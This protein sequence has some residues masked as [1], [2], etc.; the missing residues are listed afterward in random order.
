MNESTETARCLVAELLHQGVTEA[1][2]A[3]GSRSAPLAFALLAAADAGRVRLHVRLD[4]RDAGFLALGLAKLS[5]APVVV[6]C[7]SGTA[8]ANLSPAVVEASFSAVPLVVVTADRPLESRGVGS[9]QTIDQ[10]DFFGRD[11][12]FSADL[13]SERGAAFEPTGLTDEFEHRIRGTVAHAIGAAVGRDN[14]RV[15]PVHVNVGFR[16]PLVP[17]PAQ[18][19]QPAEA[20]PATGPGRAGPAV[21]VGPARQRRQPLLGCGTADIGEVLADEF[22][23]VPT[24]GVIV[25][26]DLPQTTLRGAQQWLAELAGACGWPIVAEPSANL[27]GAPTALRHGVLVLGAPGFLERHRP[28]LVLSA[29]LWGLSRPTLGLLRAAHHHLVLDLPGVGRQVCD[30]TRTAQRVLEA[31]PLPP[32]HPVADPSWLAAWRSAEAAVAAALAAEPEAGFTGITAACLTAAAVPAGGLLVTAPSWPVRHLE[33]FAQLDPTVRVVGNRGANGIDGLV[34]TAWGAAVSHQAS[35]G[36]PAFALLGDLAFLHDH[37]GLLV[38]RGETVPELTIVVV[39]NNGGG[40]FSQLEQGGPAYAGDF[41]RLFGAP[42]DRDLSAIAGAA[43]WPTMTVRTAAELTAALAPGSSSGVRVVVAEVAQRA[44]E[45][46][47]LQARTRAAH[48][49]VARLHH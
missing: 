32:P 6:A 15:G 29:G 39:D 25:A 38:G 26:G 17:P 31:I 40:I 7:T 22:A 47:D 16:L 11:V 10:V 45:L 34:S 41:E 8:V 35:G 27:A 5:G 30:P 1:V 4:E 14:G 9:P 20:V 21:G 24:R 43:G 2:L 44:D 28:D 19:A 42:H 49:A 23:R 36:G 13:S 18:Y 3:P 37:N 46:A 12:R 33:A 48:A